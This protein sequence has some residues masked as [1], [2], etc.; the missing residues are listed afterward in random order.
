MIGIHNELNIRMEDVTGTASDGTLLLLTICRER[1]M[2]QV[3]RKH[4][5]NAAKIMLTS[6][7]AFL[8]A[9]LLR[10]ESSCCWL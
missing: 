8:Q 7:V 1:P 10:L 4:N 3:G 9:V 5:R 2:T 6:K